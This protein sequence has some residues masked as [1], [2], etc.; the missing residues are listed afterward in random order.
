MSTPVTLD[1]VQSYCRGLIYPATAHDAA[2][3]AQA[4]GA[5]EPVIRGLEAFEGRTFAGPDEVVDA[6]NGRR[7]ED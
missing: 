1:E 6:L 5:P 7:N 2:A 4:N 3:A